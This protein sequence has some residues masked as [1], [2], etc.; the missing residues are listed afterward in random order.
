MLI[1]VGT[2]MP[3]QATGDMGMTNSKFKIETKIEIAKSQQKKQEK[4]FKKAK[5][6]KITPS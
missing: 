4:V 5:N 2:M 1:L 6:Q 3:Y